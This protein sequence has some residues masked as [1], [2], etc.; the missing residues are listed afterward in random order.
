EDFEE[1]DPD[2]PDD[3]EGGGG[4]VNIGE[5][6][7][8]GDNTI[9]VYAKAVIADVQKYVISG[10]GSKGTGAMIGG[11]YVAQPGGLVQYS[12]R[13]LLPKSQMDG[14][15]P[16]VAEFMPPGFT[17]ESIDK[18]SAGSISF[19]SEGKRVL[20]ALSDSPV[21]T[22]SGATVVTGEG[23][24]NV[25]YFDFG[26]NKLEKDRY[27]EIWLTLR[28]PKEI[29]FGA[30][31]SKA[32]KNRALFEP[33][34]G[35]STAGKWVPAT[36]SEGK[37][38]AT[39]ETG[40]FAGF[41]PVA[42]K[43][44][45]D[46]ST[47]NRTM[48]FGTADVTIYRT[49]AVVGM[50]K[51]VTNDAGTLTI[52]ENQRQYKAGDFVY[53]KSVFTNT[54]E[55]ADNSVGIGMIADWLPPGQTLSEITGLSAKGS[56]VPDSGYT[57][58]DDITTGAGYGLT[59]NGFSISF[60]S[61]VSLAPGETIALSYKAVLNS[62]DNLIR[63]VVESGSP[64]RNDVAFY[65]SSLAMAGATTSSATGIYNLLGLSA[66][67]AKGFAGGDW[68]LGGGGGSVI[69]TDSASMAYTPYEIVP[70]IT[71]VDAN[72]NASYQAGSYDLP[73]TWRI[74]VKNGTGNPAKAMG[75]Y[76]VYDVLPSGVTASAAAIQAAIRDK[77]TG[78]ESV[79]VSQ[80]AGTNVLVI[81]GLPSIGAGGS[82]DFELE[83]YVLQG[84]I[85]S[86][87]NRAYLVPNPSDYFVTTSAGL[88]YDKDSFPAALKDSG[89]LGQRE[90]PIVGS[91]ATV[92]ITNEIGAE[93]IMRITAADSGGQ[94]ATAESS[95]PP[96]D[97]VR[98]G[99]VTYG[100]I[101]ANSGNYS[102]KSVVFVDV[103]P[104]EGDSFVLPGVDRGSKWAPLMTSAPE[105]KAMLGETPLASEKFT[106]YYSTKTAI[107]SSTDWSTSAETGWTPAEDW[108]EGEL[109][110][111]NALKVVF[112]LDNG[113]LRNES[114]NFSWRMLVPD[115]APIGEEAWN[116]AAFGV[117]ANVGGL[118]R[119][120]AEPDRVGARVEDRANGEIQI[121]K[122]LYVLEARA[123]S[124]LNRDFWFRVTGA[125]M[126][127]VVGRLHYAGP[128]GAGDDFE[129][130]GSAG[131]YRIFTATLS[132]ATGLTGLTYGAYTVMETDASGKIFY[133]NSDY[134]LDGG[135]TKNPLVGTVDNDA[136]ESFSFANRV[137]ALPPTDDGSGGDPPPP[138]EPPPV[139]PPDGPPVVP[140]EP[141]SEPNDPAGGGGGGGEPPAQGG[142]TL[143]Q[144]DD[145]SF[146][147]I[148]ED[149]VP[150]GRWTWDP[151]EEA[152]I[153][154]PITPLA[155]LPQTGDVLGQPDL[156]G[157]I[158][159][160]ALLLAA[161]A[162]A[163][164]RRRLDGQG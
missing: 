101:L 11:V 24:H 158:A 19:D 8:Q 16:I 44:W 49:A 160:W 74:T 3:W 150:L 79:Q 13:A 105:F 43:F 107:N 87:A 33:N 131:G 48:L 137:R 106:V 57:I 93:A 127:S 114:L 32:F 17:L 152:W 155:N 115:G 118:Q 113:L 81:A 6:Y 70:G 151:E 41:I 80:P 84:R 163:L 128:N 149:G 111:V 161:M 134:S 132:G 125:G 71:K 28:A 144:N 119:F 124:F 136:I 103:L 130:A 52:A 9:H 82:I 164:L 147:E 10:D 39:V 76:V 27:I 123:D 108:P 65:V 109:G 97:A 42:Q 61:P 89:L 38:G 54:A 148:G 68:N 116:S 56:T 140:T 88:M 25:L 141:P 58:D 104:G 98:G 146:L 63:K 67:S 121:V 112:H 15:H 139:E 72:N 12:L 50:D 96:V 66:G 51:S 40:S 22:T 31:T 59:R 62:D 154:E 69:L 126:H 120:A 14:E 99:Y 159:L 129:P 75:G 18:V 86:V 156:G 77:G 153:F 47:A 122:T 85:G 94:T 45:D 53:Y 37:T 133:T 55:R 95:E 4:D 34:A 46:S 143:I 35:S 29:D 64:I 90:K 142:S 138:T 20:G 162:A 78:Y 135:S 117:T 26:S 157:F 1:G 110:D 30:A 145:G 7:A 23:T 60:K 5:N 73:V 21:Y 83:S 91:G 102:Y 2:G 92:Q 100:Y 36:A